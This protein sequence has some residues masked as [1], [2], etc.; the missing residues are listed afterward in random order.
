MMVVYECTKVCYFLH[1]FLS[2]VHFFLSTFLVN[3]L[4]QWKCAAVIKPEGVNNTPDS[5]IPSSFSPTN[6]STKYYK[7]GSIGH[8][9]PWH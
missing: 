6:N 7:K 8:Q 5:G 9:V 3:Y 2:K 4:R 1:I